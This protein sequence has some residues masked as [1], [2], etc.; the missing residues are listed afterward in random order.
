MCPTVWKLS[1]NTVR[2]ARTAVYLLYAVEAGAVLTILPWTPL[3]ERG[4]P[5]WQSLG[6][7]RLLEAHLMRGLVTGIGIALLVDALI[8]TI[9]LGL[10]RHGRRGGLP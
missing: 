5:L 1:P 6:L 7:E 9:C 8:E 4:R 2:L 3:W 10:G